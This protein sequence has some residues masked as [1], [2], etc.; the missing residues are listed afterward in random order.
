MLPMYIQGY[1]SDKIDTL[2]D[3]GLT[4]VVLV[5]DGFTDTYTSTNLYSQYLK[6]TFKDNLVSGLFEYNVDNQ[7]G[8]NH[9]VA[10]A[11]GIC[12]KSSYAYAPLWQTETGPGIVKWFNDLPSDSTNICYSIKNIIKPKYITASWTAYEWNNYYVIMGLRFT[13]QDTGTRYTVMCFVDG[14]VA[15][16]SGAYTVTNNGGFISAWSQ[17][18]A[19]KSS[20]YKFDVS[21]DLDQCF[22]S[23]DTLYTFDYISAHTYMYNGGGT[24]LADVI[25]K[26]LIIES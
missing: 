13:G 3:R 18:N 11:T 12:I 8:S 22:T 6:D 24:P 19:W 1:R 14:R 7:Y 26:K 15:K 23:T 9:Y 20:S 25:F 16:G 10:N 21:V 4:R 5:D 2:T 17:T